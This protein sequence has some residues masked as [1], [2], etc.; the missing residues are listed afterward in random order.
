M[1][2]HVYISV[3]MRTSLSLLLCAGSALGKLTLDQE[4]SKFKIDHSKSYSRIEESKRFSIF[5]ENVKT[6]EAHN[7]DSSL[8]YKV[9]VNRFSDITEDEFKQIYVMHHPS[10]DT[11]LPYPEEDSQFECPETFVSQ[12]PIP[13]PYDK[14]VDWRTSDTSVNPIGRT[15][16]VQVKDQA[17]CGSCYVFSAT[18]ALEGSLCIGGV[19]NCDTFEGLS[20]QQILNCGSYQS[21][22][23]DRDWYEFAGC[24]GGWQSN[25]YEHVYQQ[26]GLTCEGN[27]PYQ[28]GDG[29]AFPNSPINVGDCPY[30]G[31]TQ[32]SW[33]QSKS[34]GYIDKNVCGTTSKNG[35]T[36]AT[37]VKEALFRKGPLAMGMYVGGSFSSYTSGVYVPAAGDCP[38]LEST[39]IN[40]A[41][42]FVGYGTELAGDGTT[43]DYWI[44]KNSWGPGWGDNGYMKLVRGQNACGCE[45]NIAYANIIGIAD[46]DDQ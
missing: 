12:G 6:Y 25:V 20:E 35:N 9:G 33:M 40:H 1:G 15:A 29:N 26:G 43:I 41:L 36:D 31:A 17:S 19:Y 3:I 21:R 32:Y 34:H 8:T 4:W 27:M 44:M 24:Y 23:E 30:T 14:Q 5:A 42:L 37:L 13:S 16:V 45:G 38:N 7:S 10:G 22:K 18:G 2:R 39:G 28:S 46:D 11:G